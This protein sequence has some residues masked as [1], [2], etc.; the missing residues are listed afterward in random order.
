MSISESPSAK[1]TYLLSSWPHERRWIYDSVLCCQVE[2]SLPRIP[3]SCLKHIR[4]VQTIIKSNFLILFMC[5]VLRIRIAGIFLEKTYKHKN[6]IRPKPNVTLTI[7]IGDKF[8][9]LAL[10][11]F[12]L[13][14]SITMGMARNRKKS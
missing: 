14:T 11:N 5:K 2:I 8:W 3:E 6:E 10:S 7:S 13:I 4:E 1:Y 9:P 12:T